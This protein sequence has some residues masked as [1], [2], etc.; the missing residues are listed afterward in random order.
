M[1]KN[2]QRLPLFFSTQISLGANSL[3]SEI[4]VVWVFFLFPHQ[5]YREMRLKCTLIKYVYKFFKLLRTFISQTQ[6]NWLKQDLEGVKSSS[7]D[8][9]RTISRKTTQQ[10]KR[11]SIWIMLL[12]PS[13]EKHK[14]FIHAIQTSQIIDILQ[15]HFPNV[16]SRK[17]N[18]G[19]LLS[20]SQDRIWI[21]L[22]QILWKSVTGKQRNG[23]MFWK[24]VT[25]DQCFFGRFIDYISLKMHYR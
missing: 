17:K 14:M 8:F 1:R 18:C 11:R 21:M 7:F 6:R 23:E 2:I 22:R 16:V 3:F 9:F 25:N 20:T 19:S 15:D 12:C 5:H 24:T 13:A 10:H 4:L